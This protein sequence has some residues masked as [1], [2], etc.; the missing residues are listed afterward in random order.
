MKLAFY[1]EKSAQR[2][3][4]EKMRWNTF[5]SYM[6][7]IVSSSCAHQNYS[8]S[9]SKRWFLWKRKKPWCKIYYF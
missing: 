3:Q 6:V 4:E 2:P 5:F 8:G 1:K 9:H 7:Q